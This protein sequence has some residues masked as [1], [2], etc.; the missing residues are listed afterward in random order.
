MHVRVEEKPPP[1][2][3]VV[4][5]IRE[6]HHRDAVARCV[7]E[8]GAPLGRL[9]MA[10]LGNQAEA[11]EIVQE[12]FIDAHAGMAGFRGEGSVR[13]W[14]F[15]I[16][17][18]KCA[19]RLETRTR[20]QRRLHLI[21]D[22]DASGAAPDVDF[23]SRRAARRVRAT[24]EKLKPSDR[25]A[26]LLRYQAD[27]PYREIAEVFGIDEA[28]ARKRVSRALMKLREVFESEAGQ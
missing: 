10:L 2:D 7:R 14:L 19:R 17:R 28:A 6:G 26:V 22:V 16:P 25:E 4:T 18:R 1:V 20:R 3:P 21:H 15:G 8:H 5:L 9:C 12:V 24:L 27:L 11:E 13:A 23:E